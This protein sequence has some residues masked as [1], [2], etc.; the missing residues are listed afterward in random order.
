[1]SPFNVVPNILFTGD[2]LEMMNGMNSEMV[3]LIYLDPPFNSKRTY[4][5]PIGSKAAGASFKDIWTWDD[6]NMAYLEKV[7][8]NY[9]YLAQFINV[10]QHIHDEAMT[11]YLC[12]M[13]QRI[14][15]MHR[16]LKET[17]SF[18][19]HIDPTA[20]HYLKVICDRIFGKNNFRNEIVWHYAT[21]GASKKHYARKHD[22]I[23]YF[24][25][26]D[27]YTLN[28]DAIKEAR[29]EKSIKRAQNS[30]GARISADDHFKLP[31]DVWNIQALNPMAKE[32]TGYKT[33]KPLSLLHRVIEASSNKNDLVFDPFCGCATTMVAAQQLD[34]RW[35]GIDIEQ[36]A[37]ELVA[38]RLQDDAGLFTNF[39]HTDQIPIRSD[40]KIEKPTTTIKQRLYQEQAGE[41]NACAVAM[42]ARHFEID[43]IIPKSKGGQDVYDNYQLLCG[44]CNRSKGDKP[45]EY[46][47]AKLNHS[48]KAKLEYTY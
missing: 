1:M 14:I 21:G 32:R 2:N 27:S 36:K 8:D 24:T 47:I 19:I 41:C 33:Q 17:G 40:L 35:I 30:T 37:G 12:F 18:Y 29:T 28:T 3:D 43:H 15:E 10:V 9:P 46:L 5:A 31:T 23:L 6:V 48:K 7:Y 44:H 11:S 20:S 13:M 38:E 25:K 42:E 22:I 34:R 4:S 26:T 16:I 39:V 45:H